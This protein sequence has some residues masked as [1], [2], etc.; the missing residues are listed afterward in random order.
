MSLSEILK[1]TRQKTLM[2]QEEFAVTINV[3]VATINRWENGRSKPN[4]MAMR[5]LK[6]FC[7]SHKLP[8]EE[9]EREWLLQK[10]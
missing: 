7:D 6:A 3:S 5:N 8:F 2:S 1:Y 10:N 4:L 9:I